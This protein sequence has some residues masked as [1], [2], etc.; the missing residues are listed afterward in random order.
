MTLG[1]SETTNI[2]VAADHGFSVDVASRA[3]PV[4][5]PRPAIRT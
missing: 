4:P 5:P 2:I 1:L 3:R